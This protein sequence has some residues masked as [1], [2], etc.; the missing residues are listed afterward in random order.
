M[1]QNGGLPPGLADGLPP[2]LA[3]QL[4][5]GTVPPGLQGRLRK[6]VD[7]LT[8]N[9]SSSNTLPNEL[10]SNDGTGFFGEPSSVAEGGPIQSTTGIAVGDLDGDGDLDALIVNDPGQTNQILINQGGPQGG[11]E[12]TFESVPWAKAN[13]QSKDVELGDLDGDGDLDAVHA[14]GSASES[15]YILINVI[16]EGITYFDISD[17]PGGGR[18]SAGVELGDI[19]KD[20]DLDLLVA[21]YENA[22]LQVLRNNGVEDGV[23][24]GFSDPSNISTGSSSRDTPLADLDGDGDLDALIANYGQKNQILINNGVDEDGVWLGFS[25][26]DA[27]NDAAGNTLSIAIGDLDGDGDMDAVVANVGSNEV[28]MNQGGDQGGVEGE[29][30]ASSI[31]GGPGFE[32]ILADLDGDGDLDVALATSDGANPNQVLFNDGIDETTG[33]VIFRPVALEGEGL[34]QS[35][36]VGDLDGDGDYPAADENGLPNINQ[37]GLLPSMYVVPD[38]FLI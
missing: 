6:D 15:N 2:G 28:L 37:D 31:P 29:F 5:D 16:N 33:D 22:P 11:T 14:S 36:A 19:D 1:P 25:P 17:V 18:T 23:W 8:G 21:N 35:I 32:A 3:M 20:G 27:L 38:D 7:I 9:G 12:G 30:I 26:P 13:I 24:Q 10:F 34:T 4:E